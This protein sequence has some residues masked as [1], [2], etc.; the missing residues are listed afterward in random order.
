MGPAKYKYILDRAVAQFEPD[1]PL[2]VRTANAVYAHLDANGHYDVLHS[3]RHFGG[4]VFYL[5]WERKMDD[6]IVH[7]LTNMKLD[8]A[9]VALQ[10]SQTPKFRPCTVS[11][12]I[13]KLV[14]SYHKFTMKTSF[15][16]FRFT[17]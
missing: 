16:A 14:F 4:L 10:V 11:R 15:F 1:H 5:A 6:L 12:F 8:E 9:E 17:E 3:T 7:Y 13:V 2:F